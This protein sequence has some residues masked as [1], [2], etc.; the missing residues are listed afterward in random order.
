MVRIS[1][2]HNLEMNKLIIAMS[3]FLAGCVSE[4]PAS[5]EQVQK[6]GETCQ[7]YGFKPGTDQFN[8]CIFQLDRDR[9]AENRRKRLAVANALSQSGAALQRNAVS[10]GPVRCTSTPGLNGTVR[11]NCY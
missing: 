9:I 2:G 5:Q 8:A 10:S 3:V 11:T 4:Q 7:T 6:L 1:I